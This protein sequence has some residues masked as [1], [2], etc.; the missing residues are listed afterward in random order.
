MQAGLIEGTCE[1]VVDK[2]GLGEGRV[3]DDVDTFEGGGV[4][5]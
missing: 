1:G 4:G 2:E 5:S 3:R